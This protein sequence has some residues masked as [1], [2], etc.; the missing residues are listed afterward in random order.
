MTVLPS[1]RLDSIDSIQPL[2]N[3]CS[4][5]SNFKSELMLNFETTLQDS[6]IMISIIRKRTGSQIIRL[7]SMSTFPCRVKCLT[8]TSAGLERYVICAPIPK[9]GGPWVPFCFP[10]DCCCAAMTAIHL[11]FDFYYIADREQERQSNS[12]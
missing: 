11:L 6:C 1:L 10:S 9:M 2:N 8:Q 7:D 4:N 3:H 12:K 5:G